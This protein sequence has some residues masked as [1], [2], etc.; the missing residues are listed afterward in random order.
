MG[1]YEG[2]AG[3]QVA[4]IID[5]D[6]TIVIGG[7]KVTGNGT[8][9]KD[10]EHDVNDSN[11]AI[12]NKNEITKSVYAS[13]LGYKN[14]VAEGA[15]SSVALGV[16]NKVGNGTVDTETDEE[17]KVTA[18]Y[19]SGYFAAVVG[20]SNSAFGYMDTVMGQSNTANARYDTAIGYH[21]EIKQ[22][23]FGALALGMN[24]IIG[25]GTTSVE[26]YNK[27]QSLPTGYN[28]TVVGIGNKVNG[29]S[30]A[31]LG[32]YNTVSSWNTTAVGNAN[33]AS[34]HSASALGY[35]NTA[36]GVGSAAVGSGNTASDTNAFAAG[37]GSQATAVYTVAI[38]DGAKAT[39]STSTAIG[40]GAEASHFYAN[41]IGSSAKASGD[42]SVALGTN[43]KARG[44]YGIAI[45]GSY[46][47]DTTADAENSMAIGR[48][49]VVNTSADRSMAFGT[50]AT[51]AAS[52]TDAI[53]MGYNASASANNA[54]AEGLNA[55]AS[56]VSAIAIGNGAKASG[57]QSISI[58][59][60]N[61]VSGANSGAIGDP[62]T[63]T[64]ANSYSVGN[65]NTVS[66][67]SAFVLGNSVTADVGNS[68]YLGDGSTAVAGSTTAN[69]S[70]NNLTAAR[71]EGST[72]TGGATGT[73][74][75]A[76]VGNRTYS[77]FAGETAT[78]AV[79]VGSAGAEHRI[80]NVA[81][82]EISA[83]ST[84]AINGSQ[85]YAV[86]NTITNTAVTS[87]GQAVPTDS[88][89]TDTDYGD[90]NTT[91]KNI[92]TRVKTDT[93]GN[94][95]YDVKLNNT[96][97]LGQAA[98]N[99]A[100]LLNM[101]NAA[102][103]TTVTTNGATGIISL[104]NAAEVAD[105]SYNEVKIDIQNT[106]KHS[107]TIGNNNTASGASS[108]ALGSAASTEDATH[109]VAI[110]NIAKATKES[111]LAIGDRSIASGD[112]AIA[113]GTAHT[114]GE[115]AIAIGTYSME[116]GVATTNTTATGTE[117]TAIGT[118]TQATGDYS[119]AY[120]PR[121][122]ASGL[123]ATALGYQANATGSRSTAI[124]N[125]AQAKN[126]DATAI[127]SSAQAGFEAT[128]IGKLSEASGD[129]SV[130]I[131]DVATATA[132]YSVAVG[133]N[134]TAKARMAAAFGQGA[135]A[136]ADSALA[137]GVQSK[138]S[139]S[140][141][142]ALGS[143]SEATRSQNDTTG[144]ISTLSDKYNTV[145]DD[146]YGEVNIGKQTTNTDGT[147]TYQD[148]VL[149]GVATGSAD[150]DAVNVRQWKST[151]LVT[152]ADSG[153]AKTTLFDETLN[154]VGD[155]KYISTA[156]TDDGTTNQIKISLD[157]NKLPTLV[158]GKNTTVSSETNS[159]SGRLEYKVD[160]YDTVLVAGTNVSLDGGDPD[161]TTGVRT[162][163]IN[164]DVPDG[165]NTVT[166]VTSEGKDVPTAGA[167]G[168]YGDYNG[169]SN[170]K[171]RVKEDADGNPTYDIKLADS[172]S[173]G[174][175]G[176]DGKDGV[177][178]SI[179]VNGKDGSAVVINGADGSIGLNGKDGANGLTIKGAQGPA[180]VDGADGAD[181]ETKTRIV[182]TPTNGDP[183][184]VAT[185]NDG[186]KFIA[187]NED[188]EG[189]TI[190]KKLNETLQ[191]IGDGEVKSTDSETGLKTVE[192]GNIITSV[193][194]GTIKVALSKDI[195]LTK[196]G[197]LTI[198]GKT[199]TEGDKTT[200]Y[201][202]IIIKQGD[203]TFGG[204]QITNIASGTTGDL[205]D[206]NT[207][208]YDSTWNN[209]ANIGDVYNISN[210][211][212]AAAKTEVTVNEGS[213]APTTEGEYTN[214]GGNLKLA[215]STGENGQTIYD[216]KLSDSLSIGEKG[217]DGKD[218]VD[219]SIG[220][221]G[222]DGSAVVINGADGSIGLNGAD[223]ANGLTIK[224]AQGPAGVD[225]K[226]GETKTRIVYETPDGNKEEVATLND[227][228]KFVGD[229]D[230][231]TP[232]A[233]K[234]NETLQIKGDS[235][236]EDGETVEGNILTSI[237]D[238]AI[239]V[240]LNKDVDLTEDGSVT[241]GDTVVDN[242]GITI[243]EAGDTQVSLT[244]DGLNNGGNQITNVASGTENKLWTS[245]DFTNLPDGV[246]ANELNNGAN[247][248]DV[249]DL[250]NA[251]ADGKRTLVTVE[252]GT[253]PLADD[254]DGYVGKNLLIKGEEDENGQITYDLKLAD[255][256]VI[257]SDSSTAVTIDGT[258]GQVI[259]GGVTTGTQSVTSKEDKSETGSYVSGLTNKDWTVGQTDYVSGRAATEDQ[260]KSVSDEVKETS[261][262]VNEGL[263]FAADSGTPVNKQLGDTLTIKGDGTPADE[264]AGTEAVAGNIKTSVDT[265]GAIK[266][267]LEKD[268]TVDSV[269]AGTDTKGSKMDESGLTVK[270]GDKTTTV[271]AGTITVKGD[272][273]GSS[274][275]NIDGN[276]GTIDG[277][278]N[279]N[280]D[281][282]GDYSKSTKAA[283]EAQLQD[284]QGD[285]IDYVDTEVA[286][287]KTTV[288]AGDNVYVETTTT[289]PNNYKIYADNTTVSNADGNLTVTPNKTEHKDDD[290]NVLY[291]TTDY[292]IALGNDI[293]IGK[294]GEDGADGK[295]GVNGKD[296]AS[297]VING[298]DGSIGLTGPKGEDGK[299]GASATISVKDGA[300]GIDS[301]D[302]A[303]GE[304]K[305]R[306]VYEKPDGTTEEVA[307]LN[308]GLYFAGDSGSVGKKLNETMTITGGADK[309]NLSDNNIGVNVGE[310]G[311]MKVQLAKDITGINSITSNEFKTEKV[312]INN[313]GI[314]AGD[315]TIKNVGSGIVNG[316]DSDNTNAANI[317]DVKQI[318]GQSVQ[319][320]E[321]KLNKLG[322][323]VDKG[324]AGAAALAAL[325]PLD[326]DPDDKLTFAAGIGNYRGEN[327][328][329]VGMFYR[330]DEKVMFSLG[331]TVGND[332]NMVNAG[333][334]FS[335]DR[336]ARV[337]NTKTAMAREILDLREH[338]AKQDAQIAELMALVNSLTGRETTYNPNSIIFPDVPENHWAY[339][340]V[341]D[342][343]HMGIIEGYPD[344]VFRGERS[345]TRYEFSA[346]LWRAL[347][348]GVKLRG[349]IEAEFAQELA[350]F[351]VD[352]IEGEDNDKR[353]VERIRTNGDEKD[354]Q[355]NVTQYRDHYGSKIVP[356]AN[357]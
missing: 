44:N 30:S 50:Y 216:L 15:V 254:D 332:D 341:N 59:T 322:S 330:P 31:V 169:G 158:N 346:M 340:Y 189:T 12:G 32:D 306:V 174:E 311:V 345:M 241:I 199:V 68:V 208:G 222:K 348:A 41:A 39:A 66:E 256:L 182:Y 238:G 252:G 100:G 162:Y 112:H 75:S 235:Y 151:T 117:S 231:A 266:I 7:S 275:I 74:S 10:E 184:T 272:G 336:T 230:E 191:I 28:S 179:G 143:Q 129:Y 260:L 247:I 126:D 226:D 77:G 302:G 211:A 127:G 5:A 181:G 273:E 212:A 220:V 232:I 265:D 339:E 180:G 3:D 98:D 156:A 239:K 205:W 85:L 342:L 334:S 297:V 324:L 351:R 67:D 258:A 54:I 347:Q 320:V 245:N 76:T 128:A 53:A 168:A 215:Q 78:G 125:G 121:A 61:T 133:N 110:G 34:N 176:A 144:V 27:T 337:T 203:V 228:L 80:M 2:E 101:N 224:G 225:G 22:G 353:K 354:E 83:T 284:L 94:S 135:T 58:G 190:N 209:G 79:T 200:T 55:N 326:F 210:T 167:D 171:V 48:G 49:A 116:S 285:M 229:N 178:G 292:D 120:G 214:D 123:R 52:A 166:A 37:S 301:N 71:A 104:Y 243:G 20:N 257:G 24:N 17:G 194:D 115:R 64:S 124:G 236:E 118:Y 250:S 65:N 159:T 186:L 278:T 183:E 286:K 204:N 234:L 14:Q 274:T 188:S 279:T 134:A 202:D 280:W 26:N 63:I 36:S 81:A 344:G 132:I 268:I 218:G 282:E 8:T 201:G 89:T 40:R 142:V 51:V 149:G 300:K 217:A 106:G 38:G 91:D 160:A 281:S 177:D 105:P 109:A 207:D 165:A 99:E 161:E 13:T 325:H 119:S 329:A 357:K 290:G 23:A 152:G 335:L 69:T 213:A 175:K 244:D 16:L 11:V 122:T 296:G 138:S 88:D 289:D 352:R 312:T 206:S 97:N 1:G 323:R 304:S 33:T 343:I 150:D 43:T 248:G 221:N 333:V 270:D 82:G 35:N 187:N 136:E 4:E 157:E 227:G 163:K 327:A 355:G 153:S 18:T 338:A 259:A 294:A 305:T 130:A 6:N 287:A 90:Y 111:S 295:I 25:D 299:D 267:E 314:D 9:Y 276:T 172:L 113:I 29:I 70:V 233:K 154:I 147:V 249:I 321:N 223:G 148:R 349:D 255:K 356:V 315:T 193:T 293:Q 107:F 141:G 328:G 253:D 62:T 262:K 261:D 288:E 283:T 84:D 56:G 307:T 73:V 21:N 192:G 277:L 108:I 92:K 316:D 140:S 103:Q 170:I 313:N 291:T 47:K 93:D 237:D 263:N 145:I 298:K 309:D 114:S 137:L 319:N 155:G 197:S 251:I 219:G 317:G 331:A 198:G 96:V 303:D 246:D 95:T 240:E 86:A 60:G 195:D 269:T 318:A 57:T 164:V 350:R 242:S 87:E 139:V 196:D 72:T 19:N 45:G 185:L 146:T 102:G 310:D 173:I 131:G 46:G 42:E 271:G 308:D 264:E